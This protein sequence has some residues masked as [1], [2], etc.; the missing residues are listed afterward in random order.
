MRIQV[1]S[2]LH[3][4]CHPDGGA[5]FIRSLDP[6]G[7]DVLVIAGDLAEF[8]FWRYDQI[9]ESLC[10]RYPHVVHTPGNHEYWRS[11]PEKVR[12]ILATLKAKH[13]TFHSLQNEV[14][15]LDGQRFVGSTMWWGDTYRARAEAKSWID[16]KRIPILECWIWDA[17]KA[18]NEFLETNVK[19]GDIVVTHH[20][21]LAR[22]IDPRYR[23]M[24]PLDNSNCFYVHDQSKLFDRGGPAIW[25][26]GH[27]HASQDYM[28]GDTRV[29]ANPLGHPGENPQF[30][31]NLV[32]DL[33]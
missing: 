16:F 19:P 25:C 33:D 24:N 14:L 12:E 1:L 13:S 2:D 4:D 9:I 30:K 26:H 7:V 21:P 3:L 27:S 29:V 31:A 28:A 22:S 11:T 20:L 23:G 15:V 8:G 18:A 10:A 5:K 32:I 6:A 17:I